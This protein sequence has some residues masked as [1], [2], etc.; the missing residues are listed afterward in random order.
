MY[1]R[2]ILITGHSYGQLD[3]TMDILQV[4]KKGKY[5]N[6]LEKFFLQNHQARSTINWHLQ[7][8]T[9]SYLWYTYQNPI[10]YS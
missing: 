7:K 3:N 6:T 8:Y 1:A 4:A 5:M 10:T 2:H 9:Q